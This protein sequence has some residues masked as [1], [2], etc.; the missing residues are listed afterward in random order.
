MKNNFRKYLLMHGIEVKEFAEAYGC[1]RAN[2]HTLGRRTA[3]LRTVKRVI[4]TLDSLGVKASV[5]EVYEL[6]NGRDIDDETL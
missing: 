2:A 3:G 6:L 5:S 4:E 1:T